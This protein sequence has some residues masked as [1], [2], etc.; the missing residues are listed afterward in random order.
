MEQARRVKAGTSGESEIRVVH[1]AGDRLT[2]TPLGAQ[3]AVGFFT[4]EIEEELLAGR[5]DVAVHS[6][7]DLPT[8]VAP[9]L[10]LAA[11]MARD[12][13]AD[14][15]LVRPDAV[16][17]SRPFPVKEAATLGASSRRRQAELSLV[18]P[19]VK[20]LPIRGNVTTRMDKAR[21]GEYGA[22]LL[23][24][25]GLQRLCLDVTPLLAFRL[26][27]RR[28]PGAPGQSIIAVE[29]RS[30]DNEARDRVSGLDHAQT[31]QRADAERSLLVAFG[32]GCHAP[33]GSYVEV[34]DGRAEVFV[35]A[36][37]EGGLFSVQRFVAADLAS[38]RGEAEGWVRAGGPRRDDVGEEEWLCQPARPWC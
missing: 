10:A 36:P 5:V 3:N 12:D 26:N 22:I 9:G 11:L 20:A 27:P 30:G 18:R 2:E 15:L 17:T 16:D 23:S 24:M 37:G 8:Q 7:K 33:F 34:H 25:A 6:L 38:A 14:V 29:T 4:K 28:W 32:G 1:T 31:R 35:A 13:P 19:D 21:R